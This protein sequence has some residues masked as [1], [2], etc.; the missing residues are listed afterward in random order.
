MRKIIVL[1]ASA[2]VL[3]ACGGPDHYSYPPAYQAPMAPPQ[4]RPA[5][6]PPSYAAPTPPP[7]SVKPLGAGVLTAKNVGGYIDAEEHELRVDLKASGVGVSRPG[8]A[9]TLF[10]RADVLFSPNGTTL[11]PRANQILS[12]VAS[13]AAKYD[14]TMLT[15][16]GYTDTAGPPEHN[17]QLSQARADAVSKALANAGVDPH[18]ITS[19]GFGATRLKIPTGPDKS[20]PRNRRVEILIT[21]KMTG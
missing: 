17:M 8:D 2:L 1:Y 11:T 15:V 18:R 7:R 16:N 13:V 4:P 3:A 10:M 21:P 20:E 6:P 19:Y 12:A 14:S 5:P 9:I